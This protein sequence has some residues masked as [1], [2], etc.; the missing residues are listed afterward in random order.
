MYDIARVLVFPIQNGNDRRTLSLLFSRPPTTQRKEK[1]KE[2]KS[3]SGGE[4][5]EKP[6]AQIQ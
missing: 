5:V 1:D 3:R 4:N 2:P 6:T